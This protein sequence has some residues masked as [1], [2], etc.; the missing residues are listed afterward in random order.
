M[1]ATIHRAENTDSREHLLAIFN[2]FAEL[3][4]IVF[5]PLHPRTKHKL[6][7][8]GLTEI[9]QKA[10]HIKIVEPVSYLE[11]LLL[12]KHA[13]TIVTDFGGVQKEAYFAKVPCLTLRTEMEWVETVE[14]GC[15]RLVNLLEEDW[16]EV[17][18]QF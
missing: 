13:K 16:A 9:V 14:V 5:L 7:E 15:N 3:G 18:Q 4:D 6:E 17:I 1:L 10:D 11:M 8:Y 12:E 2:S